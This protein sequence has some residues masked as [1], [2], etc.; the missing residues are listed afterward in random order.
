MKKI[1]AVAVA[2]AVMGI[3]YTSFAA[4]A[5][6]TTQAVVTKKTEKAA[7]QVA[8]KATQK[9]TDSA[10]AKTDKPADEA[11]DLIAKKKKKVVQ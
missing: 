10:A 3:S 11:S 2:S 8:D 1:I 6:S 9:A 4:D 5:A 7:D